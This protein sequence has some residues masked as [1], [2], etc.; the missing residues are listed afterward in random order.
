VSDLFR[1]A[2][3]ELRQETAENAAKR[4]APFV[5]GAIVLA[6]AAGGGW[7]FYQSQKAKG[8]DT[9]SVSYN[10]AMTKLQAG[11]LAGGEA[12]LAEVAKSGPSGYAAQ[13]IL[14]RGA[15]LQEQGKAAEARVVFEDAAK[16]IKDVDLADLA[17]LRAAYIA[18]D[19]ETREQL[20]ARLKPVIDRKGAFAPLAKELLAAR[21]WEAGDGAAA[22]T[23]YSVLQ[24]DLNAPEGVR[25]R[26]GQAIAVI[27]AAATKSKTPM[28]LPD[29]QGQPGQGGQGGQPTPEQIAQMR[30]QQAQMQAQAQ[31]Q[32]LAQGQPAAG[33]P[34]APRVVRLP[35]GV[36][37]PPGYKLP[38]NVRVIETPLPPGARPPATGGPGQQQGQPQGP[39]G[40]LSNVMAEI[41]RERQASMARQKAVTEAQ[42]RQIREIE[43]GRAAQAAAAAKAAQAPTPNVPKTDVPAVKSKQAEPVAPVPAPVPA[44]APDPAEAPKTG[45]GK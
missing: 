41:E 10:A 22:R 42:Q 39:Q 16:S 36:K 26:A 20:S 27:D 2:E 24:L 17:R 1:E 18:A 44:P 25:T 13:A 32:G 14:Q 19:S 45:G 29:Q 12:A 11:D 7:Q 15:V 23:A 40:V 38:P 37:L 21:A 43:S 4:A 30:A 5:I 28:V 3:D 34:S 9:A 35:P 6:L 8:I 31:G 33:T